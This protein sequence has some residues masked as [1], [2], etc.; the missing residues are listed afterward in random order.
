MPQKIPKATIKRLSIYYRILLETR[1]TDYIRSDEIARITG[2]TS[3]QIRRDLTY[4]GQFGIPGRGYPAEDLR[5]KI[6]KILG[7]EKKSNVAVIGAGNLGAALMNYQGFKGHG[8]EIVAAFDVDRRKVNRTRNGIKIFPMKLLKK[9][10]REKDIKIAVITVPAKAAQEAV[11]SAVEAGVKGILN[12][13]PTK[14]KVPQ[15]INL[16]NIDMTIELTRLAYLVAAQKI[17]F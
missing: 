10:T 2:F 15:G 11:D 16:L 7:I 5:S 4:F 12:F 1:L 17:L 13:S 9:V 6:V 14:V 3:S 8:F